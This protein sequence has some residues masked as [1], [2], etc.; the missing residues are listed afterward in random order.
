MEDNKI[1]SQYHEIKA[2]VEALEFDVTKNAHGTAA[3]G[4]RARKGLRTVKTKCSNLVKLMIELDKS[5][6]A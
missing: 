6:K 1:L 2:L 5:E 4:V 3:A